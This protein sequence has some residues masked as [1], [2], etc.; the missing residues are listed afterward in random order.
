[1]VPFGIYM[2]WQLR[3][4]FTAVF[5]D[6]GIGGE[7]NLGSLNDV[8]FDDVE[9]I[10][11]VIGDITEDAQ[12]I[13]A[14]DIITYQDE[15]DYL[16]GALKIKYGVRLQGFFY[17]NTNNDVIYSNPEGYLFGRIEYFKRDVTS[18]ASIELA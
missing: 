16:N 17:I 2:I 6:D 13:P 18:E 7:L 3:G 12:H 8:Q 4:S 9:P 14:A 1:M 11:I 10:L 15:L 5:I